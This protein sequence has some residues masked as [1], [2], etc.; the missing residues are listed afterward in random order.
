MNCK[1]VLKR[2][3]SL[4]N[5]K[6]AGKARYFGVHSK[7][8]YGI[9][10]Q[11]LRKLSKEIGKDH[12]LAAELWSSGIHEARTIATLIDSPQFVTEEQMEG[13][14]KDFDSWAI[15]DSCCGNLFDKTPFAYKKALE[16]TTRKREYEKRA[17]FALIAYLAVH[18]KKSEDRKFL[19]F[20][21]AIKREA[22]DDRNFV[23]KAI[24][25][26]LREIG[27]RNKALNKAA[28]ETAREIKSMKES[29]ARWIASDALRELQSDAIQ[30]RL[31]RKD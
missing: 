23:K 6:W 1:T 24:N 20:F 30:K 22:K 8:I 5:P 4:S 9:P 2:L 18:D 16:W 17:G 28:I 31:S 11:M 19:R 10:N 27:K 26:T 25:W 7:N 14:V 21:A 29:S 3:K 12:L 15:C 13:W